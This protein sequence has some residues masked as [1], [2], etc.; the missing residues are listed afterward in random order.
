MTLL[1]SC[2][3]LFHLLGVWYSS[4]IERQNSRSFLD[5]TLVIEVMLSPVTGNKLNRPSVL[6]IEIDEL[7]MWNFGNFGIDKLSNSNHL[8][9]LL[10]GKM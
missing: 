2:Q 1:R 9:T 6:K 3:T 8:C 10:R 5:G 4:T 7:E